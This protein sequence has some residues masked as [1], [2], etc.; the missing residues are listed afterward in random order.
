MNL[1][2][3][4]DATKQQAADVCEEAMAL[5]DTRGFWQQVVPEGTVDI[6]RG[7]R[8]CLLLAL[9]LAVQPVED[10]SLRHDIWTT[11][12]AQVMEITGGSMARWN[13]THTEEEVQGLL[14]T[15]ATKLREASSSRS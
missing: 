2:T 10:P 5:I 4:T 8:L 6:A 14:Q 12:C 15:A 9:D 3:A 11:A 1:S 7:E 13:D